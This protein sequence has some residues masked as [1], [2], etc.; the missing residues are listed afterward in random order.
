MPKKRPQPLTRRQLAELCDVTPQTISNWLKAGM[1]AQ[2]TGKRGSPVTIDLEAAMPWIVENRVMAHGSEQ[3]RLTAERADSTAL[4]N[5]E[6]RAGLVLADHVR[7]AC[8]HLQDGLGECL[9]LPAG[10]AEQIAASDDP[11][12][13]RAMLMDWTRQTRAK[14]ADMVDLG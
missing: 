12:R 8:E 13:I 10:L 7:Q 2:R 5:T 11:A 9:D 3:E 14:Y 6:A 4:Q 1:P